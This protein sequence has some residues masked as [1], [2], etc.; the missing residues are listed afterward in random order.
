VA[1]QVG[2]STNPK[3][4]SGCKDKNNEHEISESSPTILYYFSLGAIYLALC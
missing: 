3:D 1:S 2:F 4:P